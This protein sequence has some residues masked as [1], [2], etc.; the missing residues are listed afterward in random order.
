MKSSQEDKEMLNL[1]K[2]SLM[3]SNSS[4]AKISYY[5]S[6]ILLDITDEETKPGIFSPE[7]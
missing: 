3:V 1:I 2:D 6:T 4:A 7:K 5:G